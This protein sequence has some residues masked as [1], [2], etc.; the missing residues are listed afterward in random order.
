[1]LSRHWLVRTEGRLDFIPWFARQRWTIVTPAVLLR[2][3]PETA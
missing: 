3:F 2:V 1:M